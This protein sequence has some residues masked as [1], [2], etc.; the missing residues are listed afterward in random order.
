MRGFQQTLKVLHLGVAGLGL[1]V[2]IEGQDKLGGQGTNYN[3]GTAT[4]GF[5]KDSF[6][7]SAYIVTVIALV[8]LAVLFFYHNYNGPVEH[9]RV[10]YFILAMVNLIFGTILLQGAAQ[11]LHPGGS[12]IQQ[13]ITDNKDKVTGDS[14]T[15]AV[16][17][18]VLGSLIIAF[19]FA[20]VYH[21][22]Y[23]LEEGLRKR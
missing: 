8:Q 2:S 19:N 5:D 12:V 7:S 20:N 15:V 13:D 21:A 3:A 23:A 18:A 9:F 1:Y 16:G 6:I 11:L 14:H 4:P 22:S 17:G 10:A